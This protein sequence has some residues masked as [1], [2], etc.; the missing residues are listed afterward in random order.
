ME[1]AALRTLC[2]QEAMWLNRALSLALI[3]ALGLAY[4]EPDVASLCLLMPVTVGCFFYGSRASLLLLP[5]F[6]YHRFLCAGPLQNVLFLLASLAGVLFA[7]VTTRKFRHARRHEMQLDRELELAR[8]VQRSMRPRASL[9]HGPMEL[10]THMRSCHGLGGDFLCLSQPGPD[11]YGLLIG[12]VMGK[13]TQAALTAALIDGV[14]GQLASEGASPGALLTQLN[15]R[16]LSRFGSAERMATLFCLELNTRDQT[17]TYSRAGHPPP[18][19]ARRDGTTVHMDVPGMLAGVTSESY[20]EQQVALQ[21]GDQVLL[22][23]DGLVECDLAT[24]QPLAKM[25]CHSRKQSAQESLSQL[26]RKLK[27]QLPQNLDDDETAALIRV[28]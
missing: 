15:Q 10:A 4:W 13:G 18:L 22:V 19:L 23:S 8:E 7:T 14:Y 2:E 5:L 25:M 17:W 21:A 27:S 6:A 9:S 28:V 12:D 26:V 24:C 3:G 11:R 20:P 16:L 1:R